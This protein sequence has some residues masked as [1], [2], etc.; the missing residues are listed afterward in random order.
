[1]EDFFFRFV[2]VLF[3]FPVTTFFTGDSRK[4][5]NLVFLGVMTSATMLF[6]ASAL[7][8]EDCLF[9]GVVLA[10]ALPFPVFGSSV[11]V[12]GDCFFLGVVLAVIPFTTL[13]FL[14]GP[15]AGLPLIGLLISLSFL[16]RA[17]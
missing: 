12:S 15:G 3:P 2:G 6:F 10:T 7:L 11:F 1:M 17:E 13:P 8:E 5:D 4:E 16:P 14:A 9:L